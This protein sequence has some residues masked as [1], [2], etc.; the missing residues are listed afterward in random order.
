MTRRLLILSVV[1]G[2]EQLRLDL[3]LHRFH[4][5]VLAQI[6]LVPELLRFPT[7]SCV[8]LT[9]LFFVW[10]RSYVDHVSTIRSAS[11]LALSDLEVRVIKI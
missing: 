10:C 8:L 5:V 7:K 11:L 9:F 2:I 3:L 1:A 4:R 6:T